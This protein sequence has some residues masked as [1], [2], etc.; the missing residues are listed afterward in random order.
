MAPQALA[1]GSGKRAGREVLFRR[2]PSDGR[3]HRSVLRRPHHRNIR[4]VRRELVL[5]FSTTGILGNR[6]GDGPFST[7][8][9][10]YRNVLLATG[11]GGQL[12]H[13]T[14]R[15]ENHSA[16]GAFFHTRR[17]ERSSPA[18]A[19]VYSTNI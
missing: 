9:A 17:H 5:V 19:D 8:Y 6:I 11:I 2:P 3:Q 1:A 12:E 13:Q 4:Q 15:D 16:T 7:S 10:A 18:Y 14:S